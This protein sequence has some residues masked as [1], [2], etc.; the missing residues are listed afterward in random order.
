MFSLYIIWSKF[1]FVHEC[2]V[3]IHVATEYNVHYYQNGYKNVIDT[4]LIIKKK[5]N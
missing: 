2:Q 5:N 1:V 4:P 3:T